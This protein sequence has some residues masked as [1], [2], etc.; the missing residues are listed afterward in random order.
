MSVV[1]LWS[2]LALCCACSFDRS[3]LAPV[4]PPP[5]DLGRRDAA[6]DRAVPEDAAVDRGVDQQIPPRDL[7]LDQPRP[8]TRADAAACP[9]EC[10]SCAD[11]ICTIVGCDPGCTCPTGWDCAVQCGPGGCLGTVDCSNAAAC[12]IDCGESYRCTGDVYCGTGSCWVRCGNG[13]CQGMI[14]CSQA[15]GCK[16]ECGYDA[17]SGQITCGGSSCVLICDGFACDQQIDCSADECLVDCAGSACQGSIACGTGSC[18]VDCVGSASCSQG[19]DC[20]RTTSDCRVDCSGDDTCLGAVDCGTGF[21]NVTC[22]FGACSNGVDCGSA[23]G[24]SVGCDLTA[25]VGGVSCPT[26]CVGGCDPSA[27]CNDC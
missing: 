27:F 1:R 17:C 18:D 25:C 3:G 21:C 8:D 15:A 16:I 19:V 20:S 9:E 7:A 11:G 10:D 22:G 5:A 23:C 24:C 14:D 13:S 12:D 26:G 2:L 6:P 4:D